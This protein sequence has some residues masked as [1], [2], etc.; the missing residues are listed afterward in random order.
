MLTALLTLFA[1]GIVGFVLVA[2]AMALIG[3]VFGLAFSAV[4]L[5]LK[6]LPF[7][8]VGWLVVKLL[9]KNGDHRRLPSSDQR[10]LDS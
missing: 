6:V 9:Q 5:A 7:V 4:A 8:L 10:W 1:I 2:V 3:V